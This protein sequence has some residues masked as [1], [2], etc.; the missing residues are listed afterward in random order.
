M[1]RKKYK[2]S[3]TCPPHLTQLTQITQECTV[4]NSNKSYSSI[5]VIYEN[6]TGK[7]CLQSEVKKLIN[8]AYRK[9]GKG[10]K[11][12]QF[13]INFFTSVKD[14]GNNG[15]KITPSKGDGNKSK[16]VSQKELT[17]KYNEM[18]DRNKYLENQLCFAQKQLKL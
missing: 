8:L 2:P 17:K 10:S 4:L 12:R 14:W 1:R 13:N 15:V 3:F 18:K 5:E 9:I 11:R 16:Y 7:P 6:N